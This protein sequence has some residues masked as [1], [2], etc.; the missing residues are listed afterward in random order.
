MADDKKTRFRMAF[1][2]PFRANLEEAK[3][4][5]GITTTT[6]V[7][8]HAVTTLVRRLQAEARG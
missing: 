1:D 6:D 8:R 7:I 2:E 5:T 3:R 4:L